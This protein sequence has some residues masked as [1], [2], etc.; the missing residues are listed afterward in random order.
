MKTVSCASVS[1][2]SQALASTENSQR[3]LEAGVL[4]RLFWRIQALT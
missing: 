2:G 4:S 1:R 3:N